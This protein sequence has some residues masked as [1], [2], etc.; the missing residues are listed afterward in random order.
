ML[1]G[2]YMRKQ[3][4]AFSLLSLAVILGASTSAAIFSSQT[5]TINKT[6]AVYT[7]GITYTNGDGAT[8]YN[9]ISSSLTGTSLLSALQSLNKTKRQK[10]IGYSSMGTSSSSS[11][12]VYTDYKLGTATQKDSNG[13]TYG[14]T[15]ASFY[16][17]SATTSWNREHVWPNSHGGNAVEADIHMPRPTI[18][19]ENGSRGNSFYVEG[20]CSSTSGWDPAMESFGDA[21]Y[22][23]D[24]ARI[25]FYCVVAES[26][27]QLIEADSHSTSNSNKD[28]MMGKLSDMLKWNIENPVTDR[29]KARNEGAEYLQGNRNPF[30]DHPEYAC[31]IWGN[32]NDKTKEICSHDTSGDTTGGGGEEEET[33]VTI[34]QSTASLNID[35]ELN[36][37]ATS[38]DGT[39]LTWSISD[40]TIAELSSTVSSSGSFIKITAKKA[41]NATI[42]AQNSSGAKASCAITVRSSG[43]SGQTGELE[44]LEIS[45]TQNKTADTD[46][47]GVRWSTSGGYTAGN[48]YMQLTANTSCIS[49]ETPI[50]VDT[51]SDISI[52]A[53]I[54]TY[55]GAGGNIQIGA[56][57]QS[58]TLVSNVLTLTPSNNNLNDYSGTI[59]FTDTTSHDITIKIT[60]GGTGKIGISGL[61]IAY[62]SYSSTPSKVLTGITVSGATTNYK[63]GD[64]FS[65]DGT[66][67]ATYDDES[68]AE[69]SPTS[70]ST[71]DMSTSGNKTVTVTYKEG[72]VTKTATYT[73]YVAPAPTL[74]SITI[75]GTPTKKN[76]YDG[77]TF[78]STGLT[79]TANYSDESSVNVTK[80]V[81]W[82][83]SPLTVGTTEVTATYQGKTA[84]ITGI[85]VSAVS[86][87]SI[88][89]SD[90]TE[91]LQL[92]GSFSYDG[93]C[94]AL[95]SNGSTKV[96]V[97]QINSSSVN[98]TKLG[99]YT[100]TLSY[101][102]SGVTKQTTY[103]IKV[104]EEP[105]VNTIEAFYDMEVGALNDYTF[106]GIFM[107]YS[108]RTRSGKTYYD[109]FIGNGDYAIL[110]YG[111]T[112]TK[113]TYSP[114]QTYLSVTGGYLTIYENLYE[115]ST[116][117]NSKNYPVTV[118]VLTSEQ[119]SSKV[120]PITTYTIDGT[121]LGNSTTDQRTASRSAMVNGIVESVSGTIDGTSNEPTAVLSLNN[122]NKAKVFIKKN[123][124]LDYEKLAE[125]ITVGN[126][127]TLKGFTAIYK[128]TYQLTFPEVVEASSTYTAEDFAND[129]LTL[130]NDVCS[131]SINKESSLSGIWITL[132]FDNYSILTSENK[133]ALLEANA[134]ENG[135]IIEQAMAR[136]DQIC[137]KYESCQNFIGR[138]SANRSV[139]SILPVSTTNNSTIMVVIIVSIICISL[140]CC[141]LFIKKKKNY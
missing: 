94:T 131:S 119:A 106:Y 11:A 47:N 122:G 116:Y 105:F 14:T 126:E 66:V 35:D 6:E 100:V 141:V 51:D 32:T 84:T 81:T 44:E 118:N 129:L 139:A 95:Y 76:Y 53:N 33:T 70:V 98:V 80:D 49:N 52:T 45:F 60:K 75:T 107:G 120:L 109:M 3:F 17:G 88:S 125:N 38:S 115:V 25:I 16:S 102:E 136:Y 90:Q 78:V 43:G 23:G 138:G 59:S 135:S 96:V 114:Y 28:Y 48:S 104:V 82:S 110:L 121:E 108:E 36:L 63:I 5:K 123:A 93:T 128:E 55:D 134:D 20:K 71:P 1:R 4:K 39:S 117:V 41:G 69:V 127:V 31:K 62:T 37:S 9:G 133:Q 73:I 13:Q 87:V 67:T 92:N 58:D 68:S 74:T 54:R 18:P 46:K 22:R 111:S 42:Y 130:T 7:P 103:Q 12:Y 79:V 61:S 112:Q 99:T 89:T 124:G 15:I 24:S 57:N 140:S 91:E 86:L 8:Y 56:Y 137:R 132:E 101:T 113:P 26:K 85:T 40:N 72:S 27:Y 30:I 19:A 77:D 21:S 65:F 64:A 83:P 2:E 34:S 50:S 29:E 97:P 10:T